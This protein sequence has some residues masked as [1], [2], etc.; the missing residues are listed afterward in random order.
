MLG[1]YINSPFC[2]TDLERLQNTLQFNKT[3]QLVKGKNLPALNPLTNW[4]EQ[5]Q[6]SRPPHHSF[7]CIFVCMVTRVSRASNSLIV[8]ISSSHW[9]LV[10]L[11]LTWLAVEFS[12][13]GSVLRHSIESPSTM[14][15]LSIFLY[16]SSLDNLIASKP[17][18]TEQGM[19]K[20]E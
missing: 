10:T 9:L 11:S 15:Y 6:V 4:F 2:P 8:S 5:T 1:L 3:V 7:V 18:R 16:F 12:Y 14:M 17:S 19:I 13:A 20:W